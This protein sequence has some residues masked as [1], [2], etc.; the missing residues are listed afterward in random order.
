MYIYLSYE[1][2]GIN[3]VYFDDLKIT[4]NKNNV[5]QYNEYYPFGLFAD[6]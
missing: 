6:Q 1:G 2:E 4:H 3:W 5:V